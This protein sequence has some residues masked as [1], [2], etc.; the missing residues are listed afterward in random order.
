M[1]SRRELAKRAEE[2][3]EV[4]RTYFGIPEDHDAYSRLFAPPVC[5]KAEPRMRA[6]MEGTERHG[7]ELF[8]GTLLRGIM[9]KRYVY[10]LPRWIANAPQRAHLEVVIKNPLQEVDDDVMERFGVKNAL[11]LYDRTPTP[12]LLLGGVLRKNVYV[13]RP[14]LSGEMKQALLSLWQKHT[15]SR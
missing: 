4:H 14:V 13:I 12:E 3:Y 7:S 5:N 15:P 1:T 9:D 8:E 6:L 11:I 10:G 2:A